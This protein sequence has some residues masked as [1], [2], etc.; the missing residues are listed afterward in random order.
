MIIDFADLDKVGKDLK[1]KGYCIEEALLF[2]AY[3][4][5]KDFNSAIDVEK[6]IDAKSDREI[7]IT[8][9][10]FGRRKND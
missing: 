3:T 9:S 1:K 7:T 6:Y 4:A 10:V 8:L 2:L 5:D